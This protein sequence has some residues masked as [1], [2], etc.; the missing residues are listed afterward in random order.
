MQE[1]RGLLHGLS[2][3]SIRLLIV[4][5]DPRMLARFFATVETGLLTLGRFER[6][7]GQD[8]EALDASFLQGRSQDLHSP[9]IKTSGEHFRVGQKVIAML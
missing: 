8:K 7:I 9:G 5:P 1:R 4:Y 3:V 6:A 2:E